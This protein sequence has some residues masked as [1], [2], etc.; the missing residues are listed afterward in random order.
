MLAR[1]GCHP[2]T[3]VPLEQVSSSEACERERFLER[4]LS[5]ALNQKVSYGG[6]DR[7]TSEFLAIDRVQVPEQRTLK[8][9]TKFLLKKELGPQDISSVLEFMCQIKKHIDA[10][11]F[12][13]LFRK[14]NADVKRFWGTNLPRRVVVKVPSYARDVLDA[15]KRVV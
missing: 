13:R 3:I 11:L 1:H 2:V 9:K 7:L 8:D 4:V 10:V 5:P 14:V 15:V 12:E 6:L